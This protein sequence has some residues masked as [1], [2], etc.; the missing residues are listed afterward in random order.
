M[1]KLLRMEYVVNRRQMLIITAIFSGYFLF[2]ASK[3]NSPR[4]FLVTMS[5]MIGLAMPFGSIGREGRF[6]TASLVCSLPVRRT[7][8]VLA[9]YA[10]GWIAMGFGL[11]LALLLAAWLPFSKVSVAEILTL[12]SLLI[13]LLLVSILF[14]LIFPFTI[15]FGLVGLI[16]F[17]LSSQLLGVVALILAELL[18]RGS[19]P[20]RK[21][22]TAILKGL[23]TM[24][25]HEATP[26]FLMLVA[27]AIL[28]INAASF[29]LSK[30]LYARRDL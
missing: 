15:R 18:G 12:K 2:M 27:A 10:A 29:F 23:R 9:K 1:L 20:L 19:D 3:I 24:L 26:D 6:K 17:L 7:T 16:I 8:V 5:L 25:Y 30:S 14:G 13:C 11:A 21:V 28:A 4:V 22:L